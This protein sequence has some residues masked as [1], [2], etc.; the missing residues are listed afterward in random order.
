[1]SEQKVQGVKLAQ[2]APVLPTTGEVT[3][4]KGVIPPVSAPTVPSVYNKKLNKLFRGRLL[5]LQ[6]DNTIGDALKRMGRYNISAVPVIQSKADTTILGFAGVLD[7]LAYL[8]QLF[9][10]KEEGGMKIDTEKLGGQ[11]EQFKNAP[12]LKIVDTS[13]RN[14]FKLMHGEESLANA[15]Q[16]YLKGAQRIAITDDEGNVTGVVSQ[17]TVA[18]YLATVPTDDKEWLPLMHT[19]LGDSNFSKQIV[20]IN[21]NET[22]LNAFYQMYNNNLSAIAIVDDNG[23]L[24]GN[25]S[26]SDLRPWFMYLTDFNILTKP[27]SE[28]LTAI[29]KEQGRPANFTVAFTPDTLVKDVIKTF[30]DDIVH[31]GYI[32]DKENNLLGVYSLTDMMQNLIV[33]TH[34]IASFANPNR[35]QE[36]QPVRTQT[37]E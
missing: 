9:G 7:A 36:R 10:A 26:A 4:L 15:V 25:L 32:V 23:K 8:C 14:P 13:G 17:W 3:P 35:P 16:Q 31:R 27:V 28:F 33:D 18:N 20:T 21:M 19:K 29:R 22:A 6:G 30:N 5:A 2:S 37:A 1:M 12:L 34:T 24:W 11:I